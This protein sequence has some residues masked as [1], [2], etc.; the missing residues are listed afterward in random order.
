[1]PEYKRKKSHK[2]PNK[3]ALKQEKNHNEDIKM[4]P[5]YT[6]N[7]KEEAPVRVVKGRKLRNKLK[8]K[9]TVAS[10]AVVLAVCIVLSLLLPVSIMENV[11]NTVALIGAGSYPID[12]TGAQTLN[13]SQKNSHF[14]ILTDTNISAYTRGG[15]K[16]FD[17]R[18]EILF[19]W[20]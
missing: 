18:R 17:H 6:F 10:L 7:K 2:K 20:S 16:I 11:T 8:L 4:Y 3:R 9:I 14:Y 1:M 15:K 19:L 5:S 12:I 13:L